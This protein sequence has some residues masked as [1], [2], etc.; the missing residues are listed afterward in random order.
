MP[1]IAFNIGCVSLL[2]LV[3]IA[4]IFPN[5]AVHRYMDNPPLAH[6]GG[7]GEP[8]CRVCHFDQP[9]NAPGGSL[10]VTHV[11]DAYAPG[12]RYHI[13]VR[14]HREDLDRGGFQLSARFMDSTQAGSL[15]ATTDR[16]VV[17]TDKTSGVQYAHHSPDGTDLSTADSIRWTVE[18]SAPDSRDSVIFHAVANAA[19]DD[20]S[21]F[22]DFIYT[23]QPSSNGSEGSE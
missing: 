21:E 12:A 4:T 13:T 11:P 19:N 15:R 3:F 9:L 2:G 8:T 6:T 18:W 10:A 1:R 7:F 17:S 20:F 22:G 5:A 23:V 16:V 14:L